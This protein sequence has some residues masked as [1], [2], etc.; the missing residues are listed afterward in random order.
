MSGR[1][2]RAV[3]ATLAVLAVFA[4]AGC[5]SDERPVPEQNGETA[6]LRV[7]MDSDTS[8]GA[9]RRE[10]LKK[11]NDNDKHQ[12][13]VEWVELPNS[14]THR[15]NELLARAQAKE[16]ADV[17]SLDV[18]WVAEFADAGL[19]Q[20]IPAA[21]AAELTVDLLEKPKS[22]CEYQDRLWAVPFNTDV[23][24][25]Y[26]NKDLVNESD[27]MSQQVW[28][29]TAITNKI[30]TIPAGQERYLGQFVDGE[31]FT[32]NTLEALDLTVDA[33]HRVLIGDSYKDRLTQLYS[34][35]GNREQRTL[36]RTYDED[37]SLAR[38][39]SGT[40]PFLRNWPSAWLEL[41]EGRGTDNGKPLRFG[42]AKLPYSSILGGQNLAVAK[43][44]KHRDEALEL[45]KFL[46]NEESQRQ[47]FWDGGFAPSSKSVLDANNPKW[48]DDEAYR[49]FRDVLRSALQE[50]HVRPVERHYDR[51][52]QR[53]RDELR[54]EA[55]F[56][57]D[58]I[59]LPKKEELA[60]KL[61]M[62]LTGKE[63]A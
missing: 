31:G 30:D 10:L 32:V 20:E 29:P 12:L 13:K 5:S 3:P 60:E 55:V 36:N 46:T 37:S 62:A 22:T 16:R 54:T 43:Q 1:I 52:S 11:W 17:Y 34:W 33:N 18:P 7:L 40:V 53:L 41:V 25:L 44:S 19:I 51:F 14:S 58:T 59:E 57:G 63:G 45:I 4:T 27:S 38:F 56:G 24:L 47:L 21:K 15:H 61:T 42:V 48:K 28:T 49:G 39:R 26:Y 9:Q 23:G 35:V 8:H 50:A 2:N 6:K